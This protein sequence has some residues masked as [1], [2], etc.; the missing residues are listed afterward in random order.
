VSREPYSTRDMID[1][2]LDSIKTRLEGQVP[3]PMLLLVEVLVA[4]T[5]VTADIADVLRKRSHGDY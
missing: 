1:E 5:R 2:D 4:F 3:N